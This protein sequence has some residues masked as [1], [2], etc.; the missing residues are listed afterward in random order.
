MISVDD[1]LTI[2]ASATTHPLTTTSRGTS[3]FTSAQSLSTWI[4]SRI[5]SR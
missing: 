2:S 1:C 4:P 3:L 5:L